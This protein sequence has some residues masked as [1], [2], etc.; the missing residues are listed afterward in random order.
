MLVKIFPLISSCKSTIII[1][2][3]KL[4]KILQFA[5]FIF[6]S[7]FSNS[8]DIEKFSVADPDQADLY[9]FGPLD[10]DPLVRG[11][12]PGSGSGPSIIKQK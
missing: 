6:F 1:L 9:V 3:A 11:M 8:I 2:S 5:L 7:F 12:D 10:P 4:D